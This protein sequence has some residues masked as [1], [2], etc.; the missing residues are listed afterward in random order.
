[1]SADTSPEYLIH[2]ISRFK[3]RGQWCGPD[4]PC[5][6]NPVPGSSQCDADN[7]IWS[8]LLNMWI[9]Q[10]DG[11]FLQGIELLLSCSVRDYVWFSYQEL[12]KRLWLKPG[13]KYLF[14]RVKQDGGQS[15]S[16]PR[17]SLFR[18]GPLAYSLLAQSAMLSTTPRFRENTW[19]LRLGGWDLVMAYV[20]TPFHPPDSH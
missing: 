11:D 20:L 18:L 8:I 3:A 5:R 10:S 1:M 17:I 19:L 4:H 9:L 2:V 12:G 13:R 6:R 7:N 16:V 15:A 14:G